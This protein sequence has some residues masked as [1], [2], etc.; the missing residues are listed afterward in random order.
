MMWAVVLRQGF[1]NLGRTKKSYLEASYLILINKGCSGW[2]ENGS[3]RPQPLPPSDAFH[4][5]PWDPQNSLLGRCLGQRTTSYRHWRLSGKKLKSSL[6]TQRR[7]TGPGNGLRGE[8]W[9]QM[10]EANLVCPAHPFQLVH[11]FDVHNRHEIRIC[12]GTRQR[13]DNLWDLQGTVF[14][15]W[16]SLW[17]WGKLT[18][19]LYLMG[20]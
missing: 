15:G 5:D 10:D 6:V 11:A 2:S 13:D 7:D 20:E 19:N 4:R 18:R 3:P 9:R 17:R 8:K 12:R 14:S 1:S 16:W